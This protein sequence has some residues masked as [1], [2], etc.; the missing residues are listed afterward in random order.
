LPD[1][2]TE[3]IIIEGFLQHNEGHGNGYPAVFQA[4]RN[5]LLRELKTEEALFGDSGLDGCSIIDDMQLPRNPAGGCEQTL[6]AM[7]LV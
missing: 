7:G 3:K 2:Y 4:A 6:L 1:S 5:P